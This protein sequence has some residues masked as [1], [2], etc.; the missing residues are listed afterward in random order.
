MVIKLINKKCDCYKSES[1]ETLFLQRF[2]SLFNN[3]RDFQ[4]IDNKNSR[5]K[6]HILPQKNTL[7]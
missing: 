4:L 2:F 7:V 6:L 5:K 3:N 1:S